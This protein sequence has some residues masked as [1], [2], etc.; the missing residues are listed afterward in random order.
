M[1]VGGAGISAV[2]AFAKYA[3]FQISGCDIDQTS[4]FLNSLKKDNV[5][6]FTS[7]N[8]KHLEDI[9]LVVVS[10]AIESLDPNNLEISEAR[11]RNIPV[12]IGEKFLEDHILKNKKV[13]AVSGTHG[14][15]TT[16]A[17]IGKI[18]ED[19]AFDPSVLVGAV[20]T[21]WG[22][23]YRLGQSEYFVLEA[24][25]YQ[26]KFLLYSPYISVITAVE[27][28]HPEFFSSLS[29]VQEAFENFAN[30]TNEY[31]VIGKKIE[32]RIKNS[33]LTIRQFG[34]DFNTGNF[35]LKLIGNF[36]QENAALAFEVAKLL[37]VDEQTARTSLEAF[38][39]VGRRFEFCGEE[40]G[41]KVFD[42]YAHHPTAIRL[43]AQ[44]AREKFPTEK[45][46]LV[47][48]PHM[49]SRTKYLEKEF[50]ETFKSLPVDQVILVDIFAARQ[51][52]KENISS[53]DIVE[54]VSKDSVRYIR[55]FEDTASYLIKNLHEGD[56]VINMGAGDIY[57]LS[58][59]LL[60]KLKTN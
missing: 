10:P 55:D 18:L 42:D 13:I 60:E 16:T 52:N 25:E 53:K 11:K 6:L 12:V 39:G 22:R 29:V 47:Y 35:N 14:K 58:G 9:D 27:M 5:E 2:A 23:N 3:G 24:D 59:I 48:Q 17:M 43:T 34:R 8:P 4:Q 36:N 40:K 49:F 37:G 38:R 26:E 30:K 41:I 15:S 51:E 32:L 46:W 31:L 21:D 57:K 7:H 45:I 44:A 33:E 54:Q 28:D 50:V 1:G 20:I 56:I 19:A